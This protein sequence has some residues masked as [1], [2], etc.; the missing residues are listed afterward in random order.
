MTIFAM[1][2]LEQFEIIPLISMSLPL[3]GSL[4]VSLTNIGLYS[5]IT[6]VLVV[7]LHLMANN[8]YRLVPGSWSISMEALVVSLAAM[9]R[10]Q[11]GSRYEIYTPFIHAL[12]MLCSLPT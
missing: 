2:P 5:I 10:D 12:F 1:S 3:L 8:S 6:L 9:V 7:G 11:I 4:V